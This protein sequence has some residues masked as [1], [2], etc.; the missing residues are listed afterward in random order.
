MLLT[1]T[2]PC[3]VS[4]FHVHFFHKKRRKGWQYTFVCCV[5]FGQST[6]VNNWKVDNRL[7]SVDTNTRLNFDIQHSRFIWKRLPCK[8]IIL[9]AIHNNPEAWSQHF[10][11][12]LAA[13]HLRSGIKIS[14]DVS[15]TFIAVT[16]T[17]QNVLVFVVACPGLPTI[18]DA[19]GS[20][21]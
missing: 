12:S 13:I 21:V 2:K 9:L 14:N 17:L 11:S 8:S 3:Q 20:T 4:P 1:S 5:G 18:P 6:G 15:A 16:N 7:V 19:H 10:Y